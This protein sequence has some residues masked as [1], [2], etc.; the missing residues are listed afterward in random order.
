MEQIINNI[1]AGITAILAILFWV[2]RDNLTQLR[3]D[4]TELRLQLADEKKE[5]ER[6]HE[7]LDA[8]I[9]SLENDKFNTIMIE[10]GKISTQ[11]TTINRE[12]S[13]LKKQK[14]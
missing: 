6:K 10:L 5:Y 1:A 12:I 11:I 4:H 8:E 2:Y 9:R 14:S 7:K 3:K 13:E